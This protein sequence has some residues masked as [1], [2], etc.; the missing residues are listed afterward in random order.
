MPPALATTGLSPSPAANNSTACSTEVASI[1]S[2]V[3]ILVFLE[4]LDPERRQNIG[5]IHRQLLNAFAGRVVERVGNCRRCGDVGGFGDTP[6]VG[7]GMSAELLENVHFDFGSFK[8]SNHLV[9]IDVCVELLAG[10]AIQMTLF[11]KRVAHALYDAS[12]DLA[13][14]ELGIDGPSAV[15]DRD[16]SLDLDC[17]GLHVNGHLVELHSADSVT[18]DLYL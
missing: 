9:L 12:K 2:K 11:V 16:N 7:R 10:F 4:V 18:T 14:G 17:A 15:M 13:L 3:C 1:H 5:G 8:R 6:G